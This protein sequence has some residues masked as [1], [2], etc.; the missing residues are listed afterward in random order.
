V[1][2]SYEHPTLGTCTKV[3]V[4]LRNDATWTDGTPVTTADVYF[5]LVELDDLLIARGLPKQWWYSAVKSILSFAILDPLNF[6]ILIN[7]KSI[8]AVGLTGIGVRLM[9]EHIWRPIITSGTPAQIQGVHPDVNM[10]TSGAWR[11]REYVSTAYVDLVANKP[12]RTVKTKFAEGDEGVPIYS[13]KG[14]FRYYPKYVDIHADDYRAK[15]S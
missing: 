15:I 7:V 9:P 5:T 8:W 10:I 4:T 1:V 11:F 3:L 14:F 2:S 13:P 6:E 12:G